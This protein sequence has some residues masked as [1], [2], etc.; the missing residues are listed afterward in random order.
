MSSAPSPGPDA[1]DRP[2]DA[3]A[4]AFVEEYAALDPVSATSAGIAGHEH[5]LTDLSPAGFAARTDLVRR[6]LAAAREAEPSDDR[7]RAAQEAFVE[8]LTI[9]LERADA[10]VGESEVSVIVSGVHSVRSVF[11]L[12]DTSTDQGWEDV[13]ARL[14]AVPA[15]LADYRTTLTKAADR[16]L[17]S[18]R[19]Q[20]LLIAD[21]VR[22]WTGERGGESFFTRLVAPAPEARAAGLRAVADAATAAY[23]DFGRFL[24]EEMA[25]RGRERDGVG[26]EHYQL[27]SRY[28]L[29]ATVDLDE[30]YAWGWQELA[31]IREDMARTAERILP[32]ADVEAAVE[33]LHAD[34][35]Q[36]I[37]GTEAFQAWMQD[38]ADRTV[39]AM[40]GVHFDVPDP[41]RR[42]ECR[43]APTQDG[44]IYYTGPSEDFSRP[45]RM[46]WSV[47]AGVTHFQKWEQVSTVYHEGVPGHHLQ[48]G[49]TCFRAD[50][51]N[52]WQRRMCWV[53]GSGEGWALYAERLMDELGFLDDPADRLGMLVEQGFRAAR[54]VADIGVHL[55]LEIPADNPLGFHPGETWDADLV[56]EFMRD[57]SRMDEGTLAFEVNR[58]LGWPGQAPSYKLGERVWLQARADAQARH[59]DAFDLRDF[60]RRALD[61]GCIGLDPL[62][63]ALER[64]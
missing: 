33:H 46:W 50:L 11:D 45:G 22:G 13:A 52:R 2:V 61:L 15:T 16:G 36:S 41:V 1:P 25:P 37:E 10:G 56:L 60:H 32:G 6:T 58:Y 55:G 30:A 54:V 18:A 20:Y 34:P 29:G 42:I 12:M 48:I 8:R 27:A 4:D 14:A 39:D 38:L 21:Q 9:S 49:Q 17:V 5:R 64:L 53:S 26:R 7:E 43:I 62:A 35:T 59:G 28:F 40:A 23:A 44:G 51:L 57:N 31:R 24:S 63:R 3:V 47:P 19:R